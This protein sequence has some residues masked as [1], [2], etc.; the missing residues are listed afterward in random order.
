VGD[1]EFE[2]HD[3]RDEDLSRLHTE[4]VVF[5]E[6][7]FAGVNLSESVARGLGL[8]QLRLPSG[9]VDAQ[10]FST[11]HVA[12]IG[13]HRKP[14]PAVTF[15][16]V[17]LTLA[18][19]GA[20]IF[21]RSTCRIAGYGKQASSAPICARQCCA[22]PISPALARKMPAST[23]PICAGRASTRRSGRRRRCVGAKI[24]IDQAVA[25]AAAHGLD[26][27]GG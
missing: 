4:R 13:V 5:T 17:D 9:I 15:T 20:V 22:G 24:D 27:H 7:V 23:T 3:F 2:G 21:A 10:H 8:P 25:Y 14:D 18:V 16:E 26:I 12:R 11:L 19:L 6:C 1:R